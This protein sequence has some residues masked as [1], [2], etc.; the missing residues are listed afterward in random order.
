MRRMVDWELRF[1]IIVYYR[2]IS[3]GFIVL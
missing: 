3:W 2:L 1:I